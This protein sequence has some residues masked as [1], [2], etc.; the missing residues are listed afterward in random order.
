[1]A[2]K[3]DFKVGEQPRR[4]RCK[5]TCFFNGTIY[6]GED[7]ANPNPSELVFNQGSEIPANF[8]WDNWEEF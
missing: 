8:Q 1:M 3:K 6:H 5:V 4:F 7:G 2:A